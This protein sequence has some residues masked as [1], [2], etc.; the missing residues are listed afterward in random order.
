[1]GVR[2]RKSQRLRDFPDTQ[3]LRPETSV[4]HRTAREVSGRDF[5]QRRKL[6]G[7]GLNA[8][9][10]A[11]FERTSGWHS[12]DGRD[13]A[14][15]RCQRLRAVGRESRNR[16]QQT[17]CVGMRGSTENGRF[18]RE[19]DQVARVHD[20]H[21]VGNVRH[22]RKVMRD[23]QDRERELSRSSLSRSRICCWMV[24][25][26]AVVGSSAMSSCGRLTMAIAIIT[27]WRMPPERWCG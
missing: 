15:D 3:D 9:R 5:D 10:A 7:A 11:R 21:A 16:P 2:F 19:F 20:R 14:F 13:S 17:L 8:V 22:D 27:R 18:W 12:C 23:E 1:M 4:H 24:T 25:S 26:S 6:R